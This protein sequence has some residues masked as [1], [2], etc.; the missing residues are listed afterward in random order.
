MRIAMSRTLYSIGAAAALLA[1][2]A[3]GGE[4]NSDDDTGGAPPAG[5]DGALVSTQE[6]ENVGTV[7][8]DAEGM[9]LY[10]T[11]AESDGTV[12]CVDECT[13]FWPPLTGSADALPSNVEGIS[14]EFGVVDRPDGSEQITLDGMPLYTFTDDRQPGTVL[15]DGLADDFGGTRFVWHVV[16][17]GDAATGG[18]TDDNGGG[19]DY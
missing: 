1:V 19:F 14:G 6:V 16:R 7:L 2:A 8:V 4:S 17:A 11:E 10:T 15:G 18:P 9:A 12:K 3:C 5:A 13:N